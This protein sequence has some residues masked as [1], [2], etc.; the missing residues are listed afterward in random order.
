MYSLIVLAVSLYFGPYR[1]GDTV[2][3]V[4]HEVLAVVEDFRSLE[5]IHIGPM[6]T[7][8]PICEYV[9]PGFRPGRQH[10]TEPRR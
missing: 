9:R 10:K 5:L 2:I 7:E 6:N 1:P 4:D 8:D 3:V